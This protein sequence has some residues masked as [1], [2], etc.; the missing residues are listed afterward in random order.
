MC[1]IT[2][3]FDPSEQSFHAATNIGKSM[4]SSIQHRGP[5]DSGLWVSDDE[6]LVLAHQRLAVIDISSAGHQPMHSSS[7]RFTIVF[8]GEIYNY[9]V[10]KSLISRPSWKGDS[11]TEVLLEAIEEWGLKKAIKLCDGMFAFALFDNHRKT[12]SLARDRMGEKPL[13]Y[14][15]IE[16]IFLFGSE[17]K[18]IKAHPAFIKKIDMKAVSLYFN[19]GYIPSPYSIYEGISKLLPGNIISVDLNSNTSQLFEYWSIDESM[20]DESIFHKQ[21]PGYLDELEQRLTKAVT[22]QSIADVPLGSFLSGGI[23]SALI[24]AIL[25]KNSERQVE[26]FSLGFEEKRYNEANYAKRVADYLGTKHHELIVRSDDLQDI[27]PQLAKMYDEPFGDP[28]AIPTYIVSQFAKSK[29]T[30]A[31]TGDGGDELFGG[32]NHYHRSA[33]IWTT[34]NKIPTSLRKI[35]ASALLPL[36]RKIYEIPLGRKIERL[37]NYLLCN[38]MFDCYKVQICASQVEIDKLL[39]FD[40]VTSVQDQHQDLDG[41]QAM[42]YADAKCYLPDDILA[43]VDRASMAVSLETRAPFL[44][45]H[46]VGFAFR[47]PVMNKI[48]NGKGKIILRDLLEKYMPR[49]LFERPKMG[50][51][52]PIDEWLRDPLKD[53]AEE[54][55]STKSLKEI[56]FFNIHFIQHRWQQHLAS[57]EDWHYFL[58]DLL[59]FIEWHRNEKF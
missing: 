10:L 27:I 18:S 32:Y 25:Q 45:H 53:W 24:T 41:Y 59:M 31:L 48:N 54:L 13:Y 52:L 26:T 40:G 28:S 44:D 23:D 20:T 34:I 9:K 57:T 4:M 33:Q 3:F 11:D 38:S 7:G 36:G 6:D 42:M 37:S 8:N 22:Q 30:V 56:G 5:D 47:L 35:L 16:N 17:L 2:G 43:K 50:F 58:W 12:L 55:L 19:H 51:G 14:G 39:Q 1:G 21:E 29:V 15:W 49:E 46:L